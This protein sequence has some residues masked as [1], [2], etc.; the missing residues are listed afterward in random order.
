MPELPEAETIVR[1]IRPLLRGVV[2]GVVRH[3]R[4]DMVR[5]ATHSLKRHIRGRAVRDVRRR[6]KRVVLQLDDDSR[7]VFGLGMTGHV[8]VLSAG[9]TVAKHTHLRIALDGGGQEL[10]FRDSRRFGGIW[11]LAP[12]DD[13]AGFDRLGVEPLDVDLR[14]FRVIMD[15]P[16]R[17]KALLLDQA[18]IAGMGN[19]YCDEALFRAGIHPLA[20]AADVDPDRVRRLHRAIRRVLTEAIA[21]EGTTIASYLTAKGKTGS[22]QHRLRIYGRAGE[23]CHKCDT[24]IESATI[25]GRTTHICPVCQ[26]R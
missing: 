21:A 12:G 10:R 6:A 16:R 13:S 17:I 24:P 7:L 9:E 8:A 3:L 23:P 11:L 2:L 14:I 5:A 20:R 1:Q 15:R 22:F 26:R 18:T 19:I 4:P 25:A